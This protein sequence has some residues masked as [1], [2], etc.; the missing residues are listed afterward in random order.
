[1]RTRRARTVG[2]GLLRW[3]CRGYAPLARRDGPNLRDTWVVSL[4]VEFA[5][6]MNVPTEAAVVDTVDDLFRVHY[7]R[8]VRALTL[9]S[10]NREAAADA[11]AGGVREGAPPLGPDPPLRR[12]GRLDPARRHQPP[13]DDH[14]RSLRKQQAVDRLGIRA[15]HVHSSEDSHDADLSGCSPSCPVSNGWRWPSST[16]T[17]S[18]SREVAADHADQRRS[19]QVPPAPGTR[20]TAPGPVPASERGCAVSERSEHDDTV[21]CSPRSGELLTGA[22]CAATPTRFIT[23]CAPV[24]EQSDHELRDA[25][26]QASGGG[27]GFCDTGNALPHA[28][29]GAGVSHPPA[30][31]GRRRGGAARVPRSWSRSASHPGRTAARLTVRQATRRWPRPRPKCR[32]RPR[33]RRPS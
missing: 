19:R 8:L 28:V 30:P 1:M 2:L 15:S 17:S 24:S 7:A 27:R 32:R 25:L 23:R 14:R 3:S 10:G 26:W 29:E 9:V 21:L 16:S 6:R 13:A 33:C 18:P 20:T 11:G 5:I 31:H 12:P 4:R 22:A